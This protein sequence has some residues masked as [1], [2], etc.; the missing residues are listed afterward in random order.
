MDPRFL[1]VFLFLFLFLALSLPSPRPFRS[2]KLRSKVARNTE[3]TV[4][5]Q[6]VV[7]ESSVSRQSEIVARQEWQKG[8]YDG[9][10]R[11]AEEEEKTRRRRRGVLP[12]TTT[13]LTLSRTDRQTTPTPKCGQGV[14]QQPSQRHKG[15][16]ALVMWAWSVVFPRFGPWER[17]VSRLCV[18][19]TYLHVHTI[20]QS[21]IT[22]QTTDNRRHTCFDHCAASHRQLRSSLKSSHGDHLSISIS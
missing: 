12:S 22:T 7:S 14:C 8:M 4:V 15:S 19:C 18:D 11:E 5:R 9:R 1:F 17:H 21:S 6:S 13:R 10:K 3:R 20:N 16:S 2:P